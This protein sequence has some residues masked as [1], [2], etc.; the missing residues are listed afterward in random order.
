MA[1]GKI[2]FDFGFTHRAKFKISLLSAIVIYGRSKNQSFNQLI[3]THV[4]KIINC[5]IF[6]KSNLNT[7]NNNYISN[8][9]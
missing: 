2:S 9:F 1:V 3:T 5:G 8:K 4:S 6:K 7:R